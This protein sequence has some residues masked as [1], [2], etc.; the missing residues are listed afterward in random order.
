MNLADTGIIFG[1]ACSICGSAALGGKY[2]LDNEYITVGSFEQYSLKKEK[3]DIRREL[4]E[5][6][7][8]RDNGT[9]NDY[10]QFQLEQLQED[11]RELEEELNK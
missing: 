9:L 1:I 10:Q 8:L 3:R 2:Y 11:L 4:R 7:W 5:L 6:E